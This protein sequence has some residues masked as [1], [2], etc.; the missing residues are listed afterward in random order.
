MLTIVIIIFIVTTVYFLVMYYDKPF[1]YPANIVRNIFNIVPLNMARKSL[2]QND[3]KSY[4]FHFKKILSMH[5]GLPSFNKHLNDFVG[6]LEK[7]I[8]MEKAQKIR[9]SLLEIHNKT[10]QKIRRTRDYELDEDELA[11]VH[12]YINQAITDIDK[13]V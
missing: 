4:V 13:L 7:N 11:K 12:D 10:H 2:E 1:S 3:I 6:T 5:V 9:K 8:E